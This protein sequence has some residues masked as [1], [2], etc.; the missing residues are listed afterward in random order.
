MIQVLRQSQMVVYGTPLAAGIFGP[1]SA[2]RAAKA[3]RGAGS[4]VQ[5]RSRGRSA[6]RR[7]CR[8]NWL[9]R[10]DHRPHGSTSSTLSGS[11]LAA[12]AGPHNQR[13]R[14]RGIRRSPNVSTAPRSGSTMPTARAE[15]V[16]RSGAGKS[17]RSPPT[18][19]TVDLQRQCV[20]RAWREGCHSSSSPRGKFIMQAATSPAKGLERLENFGR[21]A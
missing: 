18:A 6:C 5:A 17:G 11:S 10:L 2:V 19:C 15:L 13:A 16:G 20:D 3:G 9:T 1:A 7:R 12:P 14:R 4:T 21:V 8:T